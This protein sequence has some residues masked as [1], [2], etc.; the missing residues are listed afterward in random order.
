MYIKKS[1][2][3]G[4]NRVPE[5]DFFIRHNE[6]E[7]KIKRMAPKNTR[8]KVADATTVSWKIEE[9]LGFKRM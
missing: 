6:S 2:L 8:I 7:P 5:D 1:C 4:E 3:A 9:H